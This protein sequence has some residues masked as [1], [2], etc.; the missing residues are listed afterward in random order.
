MGEKAYKTMSV[1]GAF[2]IALG[3]CAI[4]VGI[5][6]GV[7]SIVFGSKLLANKKDITF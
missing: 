2:N 4:V 6:V 3:I 5:S 7:V 1:A